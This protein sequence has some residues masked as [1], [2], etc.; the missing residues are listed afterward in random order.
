MYSKIKGTGHYLPSNVFTNDDWAKWVDTTDEW[1]VERTGM[2]TRHFAAKGESTAD[3]GV[4]AAL[5][6]LDMA[7]LQ[8]RDVQ[9][10]ITTTGTPDTIFPS[11]ACLIQERLGVSSGTPAFDL[12]AA[13]SGFVYAL[14]VADQFIQSGHVKN[15]LIVST[16]MLSRLIDWKDRNSCVLFGDGAGAVLLQASDEPGIILTKICADGSQGGCLILDNVQLGDHSHFENNPLSSP[17][18]S[19]SPY[20]KMEGRTVFKLA[21]QRLA[22]LVTDIQNDKRCKEMPI[23][24]LVPHQANIRVIQ[25]AAQKLQL[26]MDKVICTVDRHSNTSSASIPLALDVA[27]RDGRIQ[28]GQNLLLEAFGAGITWGACFVKF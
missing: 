28:R 12:Q 6:A 18:S 20:I 4:K 1:I 9:M 21:V 15:V 8:P 26:P 22:E 19:L 3:M 5:Q 27:V 7:G 25:A 17:L 10:I 2:K 14:S 23:D 16:E 24:W 11:C 13:C